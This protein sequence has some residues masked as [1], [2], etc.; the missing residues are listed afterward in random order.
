L[1]RVELLKGGGPPLRTSP[2]PAG[3]N[4]RRQA[5][6]RTPPTRS[7][8]PGRKE[9]PGPRA[10][11]SRA[12][13]PSVPNTSNSSAWTSAFAPPVT[14][15][16][17]AVGRR[18]VIA[19]AAATKPSATERCDALRQPQDQAR[20]A[21][22]TRVWAIRRTVMPPARAQQQSQAGRRQRFG[23]HRDLE[24]IRAEPT[25]ACPQRPAGGRGCGGSSCDDRAMRYAASG[26]AGTHRDRLR[27]G[28]ATAKS[29]RCRRL[30]RSSRRPGQRPAMRRGARRTLPAGEST[31]TSRFPRRPGPSEAA[32]RTTGR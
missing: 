11:S 24:G 27:T 16:K 8:H 17:S 2:A 15:Q 10:R 28:G 18:R 23:V 6:A 14:A 20:M 13:R 1:Q 19:P 21:L 30:D 26:P 32:P 7:R 12:S 3:Y 9:A 25:S 31:A 5:S 22:D 4:G 29:H